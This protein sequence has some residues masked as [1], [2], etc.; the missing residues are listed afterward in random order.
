MKTF[1]S[2]ICF[3]SYFKGISRTKGKIHRNWDDLMK[4][5]DFRDMTLELISS[6]SKQSCILLYD[7]D[8][9]GFGGFY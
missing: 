2:K 3:S 1:Y 5:K 8:W 4:R 7:A 6:T 9:Y